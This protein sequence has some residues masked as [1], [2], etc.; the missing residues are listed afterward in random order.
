M[1]DLQLLK[2]EN[3]IMRVRKKKEEEEEA[4]VGGFGDFFSS[5]FLSELSTYLSLSL[6]SMYKGRLECMYTKLDYRHRLLSNER[7]I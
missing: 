7:R 5:L 1:K 3:E 4:N 2:D 6:F